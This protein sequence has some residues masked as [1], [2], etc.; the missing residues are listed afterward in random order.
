[1]LASVFCS[2]SPKLLTLQCK[3]EKLTVKRAISGK[4]EFFKPISIEK[5][6][7]FMIND[8]ISFVTKCDYTCDL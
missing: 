4:E 5:L 3:W 1:M 6:I 7:I 8:I 2:F